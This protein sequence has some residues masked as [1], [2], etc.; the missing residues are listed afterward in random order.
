MCPPK[1][2]KLNNPTTFSKW[3]YPLLVSNRYKTT[4]YISF[5]GYRVIL[6]CMSIKRV[7]LIF[8]TSGC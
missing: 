3:F 2:D 4:N 7:C 1:E 6:Y 8:I 5:L